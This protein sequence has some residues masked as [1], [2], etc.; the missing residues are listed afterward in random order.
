MIPR[1][2]GI[3]IYPDHSDEAQNERYLHQAAAN[4]F[5][6]LFM[7]MLEIT[8]DKDRVVAKYR[9]LIQ[10]AK[11]LDYEVILD[12][13]PNIFAQ[14]GISYEDLSFF[15]DLGADG[16]RLDQGFDGQKEA[17]MTYNPQH[18]II[19]LN[20][21]NDVAYLDNILSYQANKPFLYGCHNFYPQEGTGLPEDFFMACTNRFKRNNLRTAAFIS[22]Q[23]AS[24]GPWSV[25][26]GLPTLEAHRH[27][28]ITVQAKHMF[29]TGVIDDV[30]IGNAYASDEEL[31]AL[32][33]LNRYQLTF[34]LELLPTSNPVER[35]IAFDC[36]HVRRGD[37]TE[38]VVRSTEVRK[39]FAA[40]A[41]APHDN[42]RQFERGDVV[43]GNDDFGKYKNELQVVLEPHTDSRKN[44]I[45]HISQAE[46][47]LLDFVG[48]WTK[49]KFE[50]RK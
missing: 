9:R 47:P 32:G 5:S 42:T 43:I 38:R 10:L 41:N 22:S 2:L 1:R 23:V 33:A 46:L 39:Q 24:I 17:L 15:A 40:E 29:A 28:P 11:S 7:S 6:R 8:E 50:E 49:F 36:Q 25:N 20:M 34:N 26:D 18:L 3:S 35:T 45:G 13:A 30:I 48:P 31:A 4:G 16:I 14:L 21:S 12:V 27:L 44:L 19:E 37:I